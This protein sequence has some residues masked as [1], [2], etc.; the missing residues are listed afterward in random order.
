MI[1]DILE[2]HKRKYISK[3]A[4]DYL[5]KNMGQSEMIE[6]VLKIDND[7]AHLDDERLDE[8]IKRHHIKTTKMLHELYPISPDYLKLEIEDKI[9]N[10]DISPGYREDVWKSK[11][12][13][14][15]AV[16]VG[17]LL[18]LSGSIVIENKTGII[19]SYVVLGCT[20]FKYIYYLGNEVRDRQL[21][22]LYEQFEH[23]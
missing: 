10:L 4:K 14:N 3:I 7:Q 1:K 8:L 17:A 9:R 20:I 12:N 23:Q 15:L 21:D 6:Y 13:K 2:R 22:R 11:M 19:A 18:L 5:L 16:H